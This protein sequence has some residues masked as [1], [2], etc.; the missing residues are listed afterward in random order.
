MGRMTFG[1]EGE[2]EA[3]VG[4]V[5]NHNKLQQGLI[6]QKIS[7]FYPLTIRRTLNHLD[8]NHRPVLFVTHATGLPH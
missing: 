5:C 3:R 4:R 1:S 7:F 6:V 8:I 2:V